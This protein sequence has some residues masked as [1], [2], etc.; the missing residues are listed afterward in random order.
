MLT[1]IRLRPRHDAKIAQNTP[2]SRVSRYIYNAIN[3]VSV[4]NTH[5]QRGISALAQWASPLVP[6]VQSAYYGTG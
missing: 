3:T 6:S 4:G 5:Q 1:S 2:S